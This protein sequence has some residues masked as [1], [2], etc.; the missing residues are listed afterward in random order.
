MGCT[1]EQNDCKDDEK[2]AHPVTLSSF[3][4]GKYEVTQAQWQEVMGANPSKF[5][6]CA[7]CPVEN[8]SWNDTQEFIKKL[9]KLTGKRFRLPTEAEWEFA[10]RGGTTS[11]GY[12]YAGGNTLSSVAWHYNNSNKKTHP[13]GQKDP[14]ELGLYDMSGN[15][16]EWCSDWFGKDHYNNSS[17][18]NPKGASSGIH[19]VLRGGRWNGGAA[20]SRVAW[21]AYLLPNYHNDWIGIRVVSF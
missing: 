14:N 11:K 20:Y 16:F 17:S 1:S 13:V 8:V 6:G 19:K 2:P 15:V 10:A 21:R 5:K 9:Q 18:S 4:I 7:E 3:N 12:Q